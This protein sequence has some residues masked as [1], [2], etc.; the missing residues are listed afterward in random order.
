[1]A[2]TT[3]VAVAGATVGGATAFAVATG[4]TVLLHATNVIKTRESRAVETR[5]GLNFT[6]RHPIPRI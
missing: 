1:V 5:E 6:T 3:A 2:G 4:A